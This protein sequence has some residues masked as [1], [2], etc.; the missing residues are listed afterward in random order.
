M[1]QAPDR[2]QGR[3]QFLNYI[4]QTL[5]FFIM[6]TIKEVLMKRD[7]MSAKEADQLIARAKEDM[8]S[9]LEEGDLC[10]D[11]CEEWFGLEPDYIFELL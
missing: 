8:H 2:S 6:E 9:R 1:E 3:V 5:N 10:E 11:I 4:L 7:S